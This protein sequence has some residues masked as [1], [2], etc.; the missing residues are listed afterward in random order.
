M[1][2]IYTHDPDT[3]KNAVVFLGTGNAKIWRRGIKQYEKQFYAQRYLRGI[4]EETVSTPE[5]P[6]EIIRKQPGETAEGFEARVC[7]EWDHIAAFERI[8]PHNP[9]NAFTEPKTFYKSLN[10][11]PPSFIWYETEKEAKREA[12]G[13]DTVYIGPV[14]VYDPAVIKEIEAEIASYGA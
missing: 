1:K 9:D 12:D 7:G 5:E 8:F 14:E 10:I 4:M 13:I 3:D 6:D 2:L 11:F